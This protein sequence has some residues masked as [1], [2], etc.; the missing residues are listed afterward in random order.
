M[1]NFSGIFH[2]LCYSGAGTII[3]GVLAGPLGAA[4][5]GVVGKCCRLSSDSYDSCCDAVLLQ[6]L[7]SSQCHFLTVAAAERTAVLS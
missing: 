3:G 7:L 5:G 2:Q 1:C 4:V 6:L